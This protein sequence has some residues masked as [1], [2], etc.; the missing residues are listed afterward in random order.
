MPLARILTSR[1]AD[2]A[3]LCEHLHNLGYVVEILAPGEAPQDDADVE[4]EL[5][6]MPLTEALEYAVQRSSE[7]GCDVWVAPDALTGL[8]PWPAPE[9]Q[10]SPAEWQ[11]E[12]LLTAQNPED[13]GKETKETEDAWTE[14]D[15]FPALK[16]TELDRV[17]QKRPE[18]TPHES[19]PEVVEAGD[20]ARRSSVSAAR[21]SQT[22]AAS[23]AACKRQAL[24]WKNRTETAWESARSNSSLLLARFVQEQQQWRAALQK[25]CRKGAKHCSSADKQRCAGAKWKRAHCRRG[26]KAAPGKARLIGPNSRLRPGCRHP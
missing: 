26:W 21:L 14:P 7:L 4:I 16:V 13:A 20:I 18:L 3:T 12:P 6:R 19:H 2:A 10:E 15:F 5:D 11:M 8:E 23:A 24:A 22:L 25:A 1:E 17:D 9:T